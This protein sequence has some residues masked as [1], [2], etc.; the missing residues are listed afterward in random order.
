MKK[1]IGISDSDGK[2]LYWDCLIRMKVDVGKDIHGEWA[3]YILKEKRGFPVLVYKKSQKGQVLPDGY[4]SA[5]LSNFYDEK[6]LVF[7]TEDV[8]LKPVDCFFRI[9]EPKTP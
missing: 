3:E 6:M 4:L 9:I 5:L 7:A 2:N 8:P 1:I